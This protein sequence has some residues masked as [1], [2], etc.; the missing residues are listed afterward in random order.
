MRPLQIRLEPIGLEGQQWQKQIVDVSLI[1]NDRMINHQGDVLISSSGV[2]HTIEFEFKTSAL[3]PTEIDISVLFSSNAFVRLFINDE[4]IK[5]F[6]FPASQEPKQLVQHITENVTKWTEPSETSRLRLIISYYGQQATTTIFLGSGQAELG[7]E[8]SQKWIWSY[9]FQ[10]LLFFALTWSCI[11]GFAIMILAHIQPLGDTFRFYAVLIAVLTWLAGV[12]G[13]PDI[14]KIPL[15]PILRRLYGKTRSSPASSSLLSRNRRVALLFSLFLSIVLV[16]SGVGVV[17]YCLTIH[18][19]Y[20]SLI[21]RALE[22]SNQDARYAEICQALSLLP[23]R[24]EA[25]ILFEKD[26]YGLRDLEDMRK[27]RKYIKKFATQQDVKQS[28]IRAPDADHLPLCLTKSKSTTFLSDPVV[29]YASIIIEGEDFEETSL[30]NEAL[31]ILTSRNDPLAQIQLANMKLDLLLVG[32]HPNF[33]E[34]DKAANELR[35]RL[36]QNY[37]ARGK[38]VYQAA[39]DILAGYYLSI[40]DRDAAAKWY[41]EEL[42]ARM[43]QSTDTGEPLWLR[44]PDKLMLFYMFALHW[45]MKGVGV[46]RANC[47][48]E[49]RSCNPELTEDESCYF[50]AIFE[51]KLWVPN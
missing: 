27:F 41:G 30:M 29:W 47:L 2:A 18:H 6:E 21:H 43:H 12:I 3:R 50:K 37:T 26:A 15:R 49:P 33:S 32:T 51:E 28:I 39:C 19:Y 11:V 24:K 10:S 1:S 22:E 34:I 16:S 38:H 48:L 5:T 20:S 17:I 44:P 14:A 42:S 31:S 25:Q 40:C 4:L 46:S 8:V 9:A 23:W 7:P 35:E 13:L 36:E 45:N